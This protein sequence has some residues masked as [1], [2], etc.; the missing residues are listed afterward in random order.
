MWYIKYLGIKH[1]YS[2]TNCFTLIKQV[3]KEELDFDKFEPICSGVGVPSGTPIDNKRWMFRTTLSQIES[4]AVK[5]FKKVNLT[6][7]QEFDLIVFKSS[8]ERPYHFGV[9]VSNNKFLHLEEGKYSS[10]SELDSNYRNGIAS[11]WR[12]SHKNT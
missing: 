4:H 5:F 6:E 12:L 1:S 11:I 3:Y 2:S 10:L 7:I 8:K 9:Y